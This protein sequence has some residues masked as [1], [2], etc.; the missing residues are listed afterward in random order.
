M[1]VSPF[2][3]KHCRENRHSDRYLLI[4]KNCAAH[5]PGITKNGSNICVVFLPRNVSL[6][7]PCGQDLMAT[8]K[9][10]FTQNAMHFI[11]STKWQL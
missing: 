2:V 11:L 5:P 1:H 10:Y 4:V 7:Q 3:E 8:V 6:L 9:A